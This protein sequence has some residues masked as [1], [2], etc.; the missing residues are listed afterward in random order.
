MKNECECQSN[1]V[2][3][4]FFLF[5]ISTR[6]INRNLHILL[7]SR[8]LVLG[9]YYTWPAWNRLWTNR[10]YMHKYTLSKNGENWI[11]EQTAMHVIESNPLYKREL[12]LTWYHICIVGLDN[13]KY[14][15][16]LVVGF[17]YLYGTL[18]LLML[19]F[20]WALLCLC[21]PKLVQL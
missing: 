1:C 10:F 4:F 19:Q 9:S 5:W 11:D 16:N 8:K 3:F 12:W 2:F 17:E 21:V 14:V 6:E 20:T 7:T 15:E 18:A 13:Q